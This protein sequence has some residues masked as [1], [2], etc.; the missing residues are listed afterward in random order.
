MHQLLVLAVVSSLSDAGF[1]QATQFLL[2]VLCRG[3][4]S[5]GFGKQNCWSG[6]ICCDFSSSSSLPVHRVH[7]SCPSAQVHLIPSQNLDPVQLSHSACR[8]K[9]HGDHNSWI[10]FQ[11]HE[12][13]LQQLYLKASAPGASC[14]AKI[15]LPF[16]HIGRAASPVALQ[17]SWN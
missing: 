2:P 11:F 17:C 15:T 9:T 1:F 7:N 3:W 12:L 8:H 4:L 5:S 14:P 10:Y 13:A 6:M 16:I